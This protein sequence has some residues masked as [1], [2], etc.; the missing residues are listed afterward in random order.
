MVLPAQSNIGHI[1]VAEF[2]NMPQ[3]NERYE[4][5]DGKL[6]EKPMPKFEHSD[7]ADFI[8]IAYFKFDPEEKLGV[9]R[10][11]VSVKLEGGAFNPLPDLSFWV[12]SRKPDRKA[13]IAQ[14]PDLAIEIQSKEQSLKKLEEKCYRYLKNNVQLVWFIQPDNKLVRVYRPNVEK[15]VILSVTQRLDGE[16]VIPGFKLALSEL[17]AS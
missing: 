7:I 8:R 1:T 6:V 11:E 9:M 12:A 16:D 15:P 13:L 3:Y 2:V 5:V 10:Q 4:L 14:Y 17:F